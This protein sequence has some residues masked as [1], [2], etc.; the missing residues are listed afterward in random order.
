MGK[1]CLERYKHEGN[2]GSTIVMYYK[3]GELS[4]KEDATHVEITIWR[5]CNIIHGYLC[6]ADKLLLLQRAVKS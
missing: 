5:D 1:E 4:S 6:E 2:G 3:N